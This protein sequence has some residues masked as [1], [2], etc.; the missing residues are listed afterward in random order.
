LDPERRLELQEEKQL[1]E[2]KL[3]EVPQLEARLK[4]MQSEREEREL[5]KER[6]WVG[7]HSFI[8]HDL[9]FVFNSFLNLQ[10]ISFFWDFNSTRVV[11]LPASLSNLKKQEAV[12]A[13]QSEQKVTVPWTS[14]Q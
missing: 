4:E 9:L 11:R 13:K 8:H 5:R 1:L 10:T 7:V 12:E 3:L 2:Q 6:N 14:R